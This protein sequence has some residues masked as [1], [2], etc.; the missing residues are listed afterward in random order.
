M[1]PPTI[2]SAAELEISSEDQ[3]DIDAIIQ[4]LDDESDVVQESIDLKLRDMGEVA[5]HYLAEKIEKSKET[6][7]TLL[8]ER[9]RDLRFFRIEKNMRDYCDEQSGDVNLEGSLLTLCRLPYPDIDEQQWHSYLDWLAEEFKSRLPLEQNPYDNICALSQFLSDEQGFYGNTQNYYDTDNS[10]L[11]KVLQYKRGIPV[12]LASVYLLVGRRLG[13]PLIG[14][15]TPGHFLCKWHST[16]HE[17]FFDPYHGGHV[18]TRQECVALLGHMG[19]DRITEYLQGVSDRELL[20][21]VVQNLLQIY[22][23]RQEPERMRQLR[24]L[25]H[26]IESKPEDETEN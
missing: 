16:D 19:S 20:I 8:E 17:V 10:Y 12:T 21:R 2:T 22:K 6:N 15:G 7:R 14:V 1:L 9:V 18:L 13:W 5:I 25:L 23:K 4:L 24:I 26:V 3:R 11:N